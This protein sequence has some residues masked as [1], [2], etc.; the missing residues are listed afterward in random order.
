MRYVFLILS[1]ALTQW[2]IAQNNNPMTRTIEVTGSKKM[3]VDPEE[4]VF[5][6]TIE[7][8]WEEEFE[9]KKWEEYKTKVYIT[10]IEDQ[11]MSELQAIGITMKQIT[12]NQSGNYWRSH[13]KDFL[14]SKNLDIK[15]KSFK[16]ANEISNVL[17][18]RG[19][20]NMNVSK[21]IHG[22][23]ENLVLICKS[24]ALKNAKEKAARLAKTYG[25]TLGDAI[26]IVEIDQYTQIRP[27][28][29]GLYRAKSMSANYGGGANYENFRQLE[30]S[31][32]MRVLFELK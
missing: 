27:Q 14:I 2:S 15:L 20:K 29:E 13:G 25:M 18:T 28:S 24:E 17:K 3:L 12:L 19:I 30:Y 16:K 7:E 5:T 10:S 4:I 22:D 23:E 31:A 21:L 26:S 9:G 11:L 32:N 1:L 8:F 6:I